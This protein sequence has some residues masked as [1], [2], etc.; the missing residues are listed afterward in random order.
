MKNQTNNTIFN[1]FTTY[2][3]NDYEVASYWL[4]ISENYLSD[5]LGYEDNFH[6]DKELI[7]IAE[8]KLS[9]DK[10]KNKVIAIKSAFNDCQ[11]R[12]EA[13]EENAINLLKGQ[14]HG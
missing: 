9:S 4:N 13:W 3:Y 1:F 12:L 2:C 14:T 7:Y 8:K 6:I 10:P 5:I 11:I